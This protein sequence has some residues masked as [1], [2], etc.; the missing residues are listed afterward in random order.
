MQ[1]QVE[2]IKMNVSGILGV[3]YSENF[4]NC[5]NDFLSRIISYVCFTKYPILSEYD[6]T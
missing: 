2:M 4:I 5:I 6:Y 1:C 3:L